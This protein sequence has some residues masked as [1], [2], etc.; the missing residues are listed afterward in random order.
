MGRN[1]FYDG[2]NFLKSMDLLKAMTAVRDNTVL[3][4]TDPASVQQRIE[5]YFSL[6][7]DCG[8][9]PLVSGFATMLG[10]R[11]K[12]LLF[13]VSGQ[14]KIGFS[15]EAVDVI[16]YYYSLLEVSWDHA[17]NNGGIDKVCGI[18][19]GKNNFGYADQ[20]EIVHVDNRMDGAVLS[21]EDLSR[22]VANLPPVE[23]KQLEE[24]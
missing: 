8:T 15:E 20:Q 6:C 17:M 22:E 16:K 14:K 4:K 23:K 24:G 9:R 13:V 3:D 18:F 2:E 21:L 12:E 7:T 11:R 1:G 5:D 19:L 10:L